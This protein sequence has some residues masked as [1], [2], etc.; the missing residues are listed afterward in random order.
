M[1]SREHVVLTP[2]T[3]L[4]AVPRGKGLGL[5][6]PVSS[7]TQGRLPCVGGSRPRRP[8][9]GGRPPPYTV[10]VSALA[11]ALVAVALTTAA[12]AAGSLLT[13][14]DGDLRTATLGEALV[15]PLPAPAADSIPPDEQR[16][17]RPPTRTRESARGDDADGFDRGRHSTSDPHSL[18][19]V[20]NKR[21][22]LPPDHTPELATVR[23]H[24]V[25][26][27]AAADLTR[28]LDA[29]TRAG[30]GLRLVSGHRSY[31]RQ[32]DIYARQVA[33]RG[34]ATADA[35]S[36]RPGHSEHQTGLAV[37]VASSHAPACD[38]LPCFGDT[39]A[40]RWVAA[41]SWR[42]GFIVRYTGTNR[43]QTGYANEP[44]HLRY[45]GRPLAEELRRT[46][47]TS[48]EEFFGVDGGDY[49]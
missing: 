5:S 40:G 21:H 34:A 29:A 37:D 25:A 47:A 41:E 13:P 4:L 31:A 35:V 22:P 9:T 7:V 44:W 8:C 27:V 48:L 45:V 38:L 46:R 28:M 16:T 36:A 19:V 32:R 30:V 39:T 17:S 3:I 42:H 49:R 23:G 12:I 15:V 10:P 20:V 11:R 2:P 26:A 18:W 14:P 6:R 1:P 33:T 24:R 43:E